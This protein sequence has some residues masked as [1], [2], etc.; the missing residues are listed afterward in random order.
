[1][2]A[3]YTISLNNEEYNLVMAA[4]ASYRIKGFP[5][6]RS[7][8]SATITQRDRQLWASLGMEL[9]HRFHDLKEV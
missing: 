6:G 3:E 7:S 4:M 8:P 9:W 2:E 5:L 1:M